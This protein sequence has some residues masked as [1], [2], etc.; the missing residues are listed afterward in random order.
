M[1]YTIEQQGTWGAAEA[2]EIGTDK[3]GNRVLYGAND[4]RRPAGAAM[5][6]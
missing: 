6:Y 3:D 5:G 1:G 2:I 4:D